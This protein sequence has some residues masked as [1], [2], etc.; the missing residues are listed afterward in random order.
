MNFEWDENKNRRNQKKHGTSF[1]QA[2]AL[3]T[4]SEFIE[5]E[6]ETDTETLV[7]RLAIFEKKHWAVVY[8]ERND[9]IRII[10]FRRA[11]KWE[12]RLYEENKSKS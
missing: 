3:F 8:T 7:V 10:S 12:M 9:S 1:D 4:T 2:R 6:V 11:K 5:I